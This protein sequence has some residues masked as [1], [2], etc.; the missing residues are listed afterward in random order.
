MFKSLISQDGGPVYH[1]YLCFNLFFS[2][3]LFLDAIFPNFTYF[4]PPKFLFV[5]SIFF[6]CSYTRPKI[7]S[8][9]TWFSIDLAKIWTWNSFNHFCRNCRNFNDWI[10]RAFSSCELIS[11]TEWFCSSQTGR[12]FFTW[13]FW[14]FHII[15]WL[16]FCLD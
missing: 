1:I 13:I 6:M 9:R 12:A 7:F 3:S 8:M 11:S 14:N 5:F 16:R 2:F 4:I 15:W 10:R